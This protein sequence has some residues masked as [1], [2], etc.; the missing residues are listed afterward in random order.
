MKSLARCSI[1]FLFALL[2]LSVALGAEIQRSSDIFFS[3]EIRE[4]LRAQNAMPAFW[5]GFLIIEAERAVEAC[6]RLRSSEMRTR[7]I[8]RVQC[9][10]QLSD[11]SPAVREWA[12][13]FRLR[14]P[15]PALREIQEQINQT[16]AKLTLLLGARDVLQILRMDPLGTSNE[17]ME[18]A[19]KRMKI[20]FER[21][22]GIYMDSPTKRAILPIQF[23]HPP[24]E[25]DQTAAFLAEW[26]LPGVFLG[27]HASYF[28]NE[29]RVMGDISIVST[30]GIAVLV[31]FSLFLIFAR[32]GRAVLLLPAVFV[33]ISLATTA[34][35]WIFGSIH[36]LTLAFGSGIIGLALDYGL[37][38]AFNIRSH[39]TWISN[40]VGLVTTLCGLVILSLSEIPLIRQMMVFSILGLLFGYI[41]MYILLKYWPKKFSVAAF[42][43]HVKAPA[44]MTF[45]VFILLVIGLLGSAI[46]NP[47]LDLKQFDFL[48]P[49]S[50]RIADWFW[51]KLN[52]S[53]PL[54]RYHTKEDDLAQAQVEAE[55][56]RAHNIN[57]ENMARYL[58]SLSEQQKNLVTWQTC[59]ETLSN[60]KPE[61]RKFFKESL[62]QMFCTPA[63]PRAHNS[64]YTSHLTSD[65]SGLTLW[66]TETAEQSKQVKA[67][68][69]DAESMAEVARRFPNVLA[70]ELRWMV[71]VALILT[72]LVILIY[73]RSFWYLILTFVPF[74]SGL[75][76][77]FL[78]T[79][80]FQ[81]KVSFISVIGL[82]MVFGFSIDYGLFLLDVFRANDSE[83]SVLTALF[84]AAL[85]NIIGFLP[86]VFALHP[87]L[88]H[89]GTALVFGT[90]GTFIGSVFG[91]P[92]FLQILRKRRLV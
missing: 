19:T 17:L 28:E 86:L 9:R 8:D 40:F 76:L 2:V 90:L 78:V 36:G 31:A 1:G 14:K 85:T 38:G 25:I 6:D 42:P 22:D 82:V 48:P 12:L 50:A 91:I 75:G 30:I 59:E 51:P 35:I 34:T 18:L 20:P 4:K 65:L 62:H 67:Q 5:W 66:F 84:F 61:V 52:F 39:Q 88:N 79:F 69:P 15:A 41:I 53:P 10:E 47:S 64:A 81:L 3:K 89:L 11:V 24:S 77:F 21:Q 23:R 71:P 43:F 60:L 56:S 80:I 45:A 49:T 27:P 54:V 33:A 46:S 63:Q 16:M 70:G 44:M 57:F 74:L 32:R 72:A 37:H 73:Y 87:V 29:R 92:G 83:E 68:F 13:D 58:P 26:N 7:W 55:W